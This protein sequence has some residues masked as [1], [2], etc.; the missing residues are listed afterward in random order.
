M[1]LPN[2]LPVEIA[3]LIEAC[4]PEPGD[5]VYLR[6]RMGRHFEGVRLT[7]APDLLG[8]KVAAQKLSDALVATGPETD[9]RFADIVIGLDSAR[10]YV[11]RDRRGS[12]TTVGA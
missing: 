9:E 5:L 3:R 10:P 6:T 11:A 1:T 12:P 8:L 7:T 4:N 2:D